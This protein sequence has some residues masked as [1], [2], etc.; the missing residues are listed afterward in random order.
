MAL[1]RFLVA[2]AALAG[3]AVVARIRLPA[4]RDL[5]GLMALG[6]V[7][8]AIYHVALN[9]GEVSVDAGTASLLLNTGPAFTALLAV[10]ALGERLRPLGWLG[11]AIGFAGV[12]VIVAGRGHGLRVAPGAPLVLLAAALLSVSFVAQKPYLRRYS[13]IELTSYTF[14]AGTM[15]LLVFLPGLPGAVRTAPL[16]TT[17]AMLYLGLFCT[18]LANVS[19]AYALA[20]SPAT[21]AASYLYVLPGLAIVVA[22]RWLGEVPSVLSLAGGGLTLTGIVLVQRRPQ[23]RIRAKPP[24][25]TQ[26]ADDSK[27]ARNDSEATRCCSR[28]AE[29]PAAGAWF[30]KRANTALACSV[31][32][33][34]ARLADVPRQGCRSLW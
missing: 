13:A 9:Y 3:Y 17:A 2:S 26:P 27:R 29:T 4:R 34:W 20:R 8:V 30:R 5:P 32:T 25:S 18:A 11:I 19:W 7:G 28:C 16:G 15:A 22:W 6:I 10:P 23:W 12:V 33:R 1:L 31:L 24:L 21:R 14:W